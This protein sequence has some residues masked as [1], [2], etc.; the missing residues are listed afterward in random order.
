MINGL[1]LF[2]LTE[3]ETYHQMVRYEQYQ[4]TICLNLC[5]YGQE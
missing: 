3:N 1:L 5:Q 2:I 4:Q